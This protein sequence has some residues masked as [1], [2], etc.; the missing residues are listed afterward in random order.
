MIERLDRL[1]TGRNVLITFGLALGCL[2]GA[3]V[4]ATA[5]HARTGGH[6]ILDLG[7]ARNALDEPSGYTA[8]EAYA[9]IAAW[10]PAGRR[11]QVLFTVTGDVLLPMATLLFAAL[12]L[13]YAARRL[14]LRPWLRTTLLAL[15][16]AYLLCDYLEN[17]G[18]VTVV[19]AYPRRLDPMVGV[20]DWLRGAKTV[21]VTAAVLAALGALA[22]GLV[23]S[24]RDRLA[25]AR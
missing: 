11:D 15:P 9:L 8:D 14:G 23:R 20:L 21:T 19:L 13:V 22:L 24:R 3:N 17:I 1:A 10:G 4:F 5:F 7:G 2:V 16:A 18:I 25:A 12:A 6:G